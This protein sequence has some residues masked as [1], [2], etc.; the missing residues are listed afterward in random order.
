ML[1]TLLLHG[2]WSVDHVR[3][4]VSRCDTQGAAPVIVGE[5]A[6]L[7]V[8][9]LS[10]C[11]RVVANEQA[12]KHVG[13]AL[14]RLVPLALW[15]GDLHAAYAALDHWAQHIDRHYPKDELDWLLELLE[16][17][18][19]RMQARADAGRASLALPPR[20]DP[21]NPFGRLIIS[22]QG[23]RMDVRDVTAHVAAELAT[24]QHPAA[25]TG[26]AAVG[27]RALL[28]HERRI[29]SLERDRQFTRAEGFS[30][31]VALAMASRLPGH[32]KLALRAL[33]HGPRARP[34][35]TSAHLLVRAAGAEGFL[36]SEGL[37]EAGLAH[38]V[39]RAGGRR[40][41]PRGLHAGGEDR[42]G[43]PTCRARADSP[44]RLEG[45]LS[46]H[47]SS[48]VHAC[49]RRQSRPCVAVACGQP[50]A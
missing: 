12:D 48:R 39:G 2:V 15:H 6:D 50:I 34:C 24:V 13:H 46:A 27:W 7:L 30:V 37:G 41:R 16:L 49:E 11:F 36:T 1:R 21:V 8:P 42:D 3:D 10:W 18:A 4:F 38:H 23:A 25:P 44:G 9:H 14:R 26:G 35:R 17:N 20:S 19:A 5:L 22:A 43:L 31:R 47:A 40:E 28:R 29:R 45:R 32:R 33:A